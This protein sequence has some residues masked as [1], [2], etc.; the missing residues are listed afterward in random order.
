MILLSPREDIN[1]PPGR[2]EKTLDSDTGQAYLP[3][4]VAGLLVR[5]KPFNPNEEHMGS[6][7][8]GNVTPAILIGPAL[9][10]TIKIDRAGLACVR[11]D[12]RA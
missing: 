9:P 7:T 2:I 4:V 11:G 5:D 6:T 3:I 1:D 8:F 10:Q 12:G